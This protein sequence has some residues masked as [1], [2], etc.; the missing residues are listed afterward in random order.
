MEDPPEKVD[1]AII[2]APAGWLVKEALRVLEKAGTLAINAIYMSPLP[3]LPYD[4]L[5]NEKK[6][7]SVANVTR[8]DAEQFLKIAGGIPIKTDVEVFPLEE[9]NEALKKLKN[10]EIKGAAV[11]KIS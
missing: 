6:V 9:A 4:L 3:E 2:F 8:L 1:S 11:L 10:S 5:W 7:R